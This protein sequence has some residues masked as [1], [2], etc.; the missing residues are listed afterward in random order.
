MKI[1]ILTE[2]ELQHI[3]TSI[4]LL[5][6]DSLV[7]LKNKKSILKTKIIIPHSLIET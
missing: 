7:L 2:T 4:H 1:F 3:E 5:L 6:K